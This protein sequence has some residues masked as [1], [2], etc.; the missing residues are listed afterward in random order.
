[1]QKITSDL[2]ESARKLVFKTCHYMNSE[3]WKSYLEL[4]D[5]NEFHYQVTCYSP[6][7]RKQQIWADHNYKSMKSTF[8]LLPRHNSDHSKL[9]RHANVIDVDT[10]QDNQ[11]VVT[12]GL[13]IY[14][15]QLD[16]TQ[17]YVESGQT[18]LYLIGTYRDIVN[19]HG[20]RAILLSRTVELETR[21]LDVGSHKPF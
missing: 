2:I 21:Q 10:N 5:P 18:S 4:C 8:D 13:T 17:S 9:I 12:S 11:I 14:K 6:E 19:L 15:T 16:G 1:M 20:D 7:I 3:N